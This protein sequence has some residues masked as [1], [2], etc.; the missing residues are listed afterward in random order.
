[1]VSCS[2]KPHTVIM[3]KTG[4]IS[5]D[6]INYVDRSL[7]SHALA[8]GEVTRK[9]EDLLSW[10]KRTDQSAN[11][12]TLARSSHVPKYSGAKGGKPPTSKQ[13]GKLNCQFNRTPVHTPLH[14]GKHFFQ[15]LQIPCPSHMH[16]IIFHPQC[17]TS[18]FSQPF[19][20][21]FLIACHVK[22]SSRSLKIFHTL[23]LCRLHR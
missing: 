16:I 18:W 17:N 5:C 4:Q 13:R 6:C 23:W 3:H 15:L 10:Y 2:Y 7:C 12:W 14:K 22:I 8:V 9:L 20:I 11:L 1:M 21:V 19:L